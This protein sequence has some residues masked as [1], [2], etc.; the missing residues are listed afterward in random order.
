MPDSPVNLMFNRSRRRLLAT[1]LLRPDERFH[2]RELGRMTGIS[3]GTIHREL[4]ALAEAGILVREQVGNQVLYSADRRCPVYPELSA[5]FR[6][7]SGL[8]DLLRDA[9]AD[10]AGKI[11][12]AFVFGSLAGGEPRP[13]SDVDICVIGDVSLLDVVTA[14]SRPADELGREVNPVVMTAAKFSEQASKQERFIMRLLD[15]PKIFLMGDDHEFAKLA[16]DRAAQ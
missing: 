7:T 9:L 11:E 12:L 8:A 2:V 13:D 10:L 4:R 5:I 6:K 16:G 1:L 15:E 14:L 3:A